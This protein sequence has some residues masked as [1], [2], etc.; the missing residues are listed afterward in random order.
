M[1]TRRNFLRRA[2]TGTALLS[3]GSMPPQFLQAAADQA[4]AGKTGEDRILVV[5]EMAGGNDGL[6]TVVPFAD[7]AYRKA[8][9]GLALSEAD[10]IRIDDSLGLHSSLR[11]FADLLNDGSLAI[12]QGV[13][14]DNP[15]RSHFES[16]DIWHTC[17]RKD[18][19]RVDGWLGRFLESSGLPDG[20]DPGGLHLGADK[21][22]FALMSRSVR[23]PSI[24]SLEQFRLNGV[25]RE[26]FRA[27]VQELTAARGAE[28][29]DLL[30]F[31]QSSTSSAIMASKRIEATGRKHRPSGEYPATG[32]G[33]KLKTV[34][35][36]I[37]SGLGTRIFYVQIDGFDTHAQQPNAHA[38]LLRQLG[39][40]VRSFISDMAVQGQGD[41]VAVMC[42]S[43]F[44]RRVA[45]N[46]SE[47]TDHGTAGPMFVVG[48]KVRAGLIG[49]HPSLTDLQ[50]G[51]LKHH[52]DFRQ[53]YT[54]VLGQ[55][56]GCDPQPVVRQAFNSLPLF[57]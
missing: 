38:G 27:A 49:A 25:D 43:E 40:A 11:G 51:D 39:D 13:G 1:T 52:T 12:V 30:G 7:D 29:N 18:E 20:S 3:L 10:V 6:N 22:P 14:Y 34:A 56:L 48:S 15:N 21:Q 53:V 28:D 47:G 33:E 19:T 26:Q 57:A 23:V 36:L 31:V 50:D 45:E 9:P 42:F 4:V 32:L 44:G 24:R 16:M 46:A 17:Q 54:S 2:G 37:M 41:R 8:R 55:W 5:I 35:G